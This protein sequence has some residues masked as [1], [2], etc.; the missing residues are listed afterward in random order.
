MEKHGRLAVLQP[1]QDAMQP[2]GY[3]IGASFTA[4]L[5][6]AEQTPRFGLYVRVYGSIAW[7]CGTV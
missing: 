5:N 3:K 2:D 7:L 4:A 6:I 1:R